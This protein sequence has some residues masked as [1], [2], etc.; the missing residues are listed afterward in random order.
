MIEPIEALKQKYA[1]QWLAVKV[2]KEENWVPLEGELVA[3]SR[4]KSEVY[5]AIQ[6]SNEVLDIFFAG[7]KIKQGVL[8]ALVC[9]I[10]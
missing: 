2:T 9:R 6:D 5:R 8:W 1:N 3:H 4:D 10:R 7:E